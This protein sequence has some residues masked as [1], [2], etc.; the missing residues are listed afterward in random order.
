MLSSQL[1][2]GLAS[3]LFPLGSLTKIVYAF[4]ICVPSI[5]LDLITLVDL[6]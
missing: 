5:L 3:G 6:V 2:L 4:L 1:R